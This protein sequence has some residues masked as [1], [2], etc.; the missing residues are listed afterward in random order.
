MDWG[1][2]V[3][4]ITNNVIWGYFLRIPLCMVPAGRFLPDCIWWA[5]KKNICDGRWIFSPNADHNRTNGGEFL[6][7]T[8]GVRVNFANT[9]EQGFTRFG[10]SIQITTK[11]VNV[12]QKVWNVEELANL[13]LGSGHKTSVWTHALWTHIIRAALVVQVHSEQAALK[14]LDLCCHWS[15]VSVQTKTS[16]R[17]HTICGPLKAAKSSP[18]MVCSPMA[19]D[20]RTGKSTHHKGGSK[21]KA[22]KQP[23]VVA[24]PPLDKKAHSVLREAEIKLSHTRTDKPGGV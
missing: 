23:E 8:Y 20:N 3:Y 21:L 5:A 11:G 6:W 9:D 17:T 18:A 13:T 7:E 14:P 19:K 2:Q 24:G 1:D 16:M 15:L 12:M 22:V 4:E 10:T